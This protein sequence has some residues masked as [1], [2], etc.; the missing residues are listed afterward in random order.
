M[1]AK[2]EILIRHLSFEV[3]Q[4]FPK[5]QNFSD[6]EKSGFI[7]RKSVRKKF[8]L[9]K[10]GFR[11]IYYKDMTDEWAIYT[12]N[13]KESYEKQLNPLSEPEPE[14]DGGF[15]K[16]NKKNNKS[17]KKIKKKSNKKS[18]KKKK[19]RKKIKKSNKKIKKSNKKIKN[20]NKN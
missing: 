16:Y 2:L 7:F 5:F 1:C 6:F 11:L 13:R 14:L 20:S 17:N 19:K 4:F 12:K 8:E 10:N 9:E 3:F 18:N 15:K